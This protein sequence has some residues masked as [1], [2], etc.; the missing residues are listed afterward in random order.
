MVAAMEGDRGLALLQTA[1]AL[2]GGDT[3]FARLQQFANRA[4][5]PI[6]THGLAAWSGGEGNYWGH[7]AIIRTEAFAASCGLP[8]LP[9]KPPLGGHVL[10]RRARDPQAAES[11]NRRR[12]VRVAAG[13]VPDRRAIEVERGDPEAG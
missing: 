8:T 3:L 10:S 5:G 1:P 13:R 4:C 2:A 11:N 12:K 7:N 6:V 9:G